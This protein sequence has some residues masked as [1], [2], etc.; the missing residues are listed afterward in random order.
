MPRDSANATPECQHC[1]HAFETMTGLR[2]HINKGKCASFDAQRTT[3][4]RTADPTL[5]EALTNGH[6][7][8]CLLQPT[9]RV[10]LTLRCQLCGVAYSTPAQLMLRLQ[11][12][13]GPQQVQ[14]QEWLGYL[15]RHLGPPTHCYCNT[16]PC[17]LYSNHVCVPLRQISMLFDKLQAAQQPAIF[18]PWTFDKVLLRVNLHHAL[19]ASL[20]DQ[21]AH[22]L[23][24]RNF[25]AL[26]R[27]SS[28]HQV[29]G[30]T[31]LCCGVE[32]SIVALAQHLQQQHS[33]L[34]MGTNAL[35]GYV[36]N[37]AIRLHD[38]DANTQRCPLCSFDFGRCTT[39]QGHLVVCP[40][41]HQLC[42]LVTSITHGNRAACRD[43]SNGDRG[44]PLSHLAPALGQS[45]LKMPTWRPGQEDQGRGEK[46]KTGQE[47]AGK[48]K[49]KGKGKHKRQAHSP[50]DADPDMQHLV[51]T[52]GQL[53]V[54]LDK[55][56]RLMQGES[57][58]VALCRQDRRASCR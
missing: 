30:T 26:L 17:Q 2:M 8:E 39:P 32:Y 27:D 21:V 54:R 53:V 55:Q 5:I 10:E 9:V 23:V 29:L 56:V 42:L 38:I 35:C 18:A 28:I 44:R 34:L 43:C 4:T 37:H 45:C 49:G 41:V 14:A 47:P 33:H 25:E 24:E 50:T 46:Q 15:R 57:S 19:P 1:H 58:L 22:Y 7:W 51:K 36:A 16:A 12:A 52:I 13:H 31:C 11:T 48:G 3:I 6:L 40:I 20:I